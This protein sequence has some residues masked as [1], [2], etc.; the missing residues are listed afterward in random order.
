MEGPPHLP[1]EPNKRQPPPSVTPPAPLVCLLPSSIVP[2]LLLLKAETP[3]PPHCHP[4]TGEDQNRIP[5]TPPP[6]PLDCGKPPCPGVAIRQSS[7]EALVAGH[8]GVHGGTVDQPSLVRS[9]AHGLSPCSFQLKKE[10]Q[11]QEIPPYL[12]KSPCLCCKLSHSP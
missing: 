9:T 4:K 3:P 1:P 10:I 5:V 11:S 6:S 8:C 12:Q 2:A 7:G